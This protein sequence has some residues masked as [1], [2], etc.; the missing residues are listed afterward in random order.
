MNVVIPGTLITIIAS[1]HLRNFLR[2]HSRARFM[3]HPAAAKLS[4]AD[5]LLDRDLVDRTEP[6]HIQYY[7]PDFINDH[8]EATFEDLA[9]RKEDKV[10]LQLFMANSF[11][12]VLFGYQDCPFG[13]TVGIP[14]YYMW[15]TVEEVQFEEVIQMLWGKEIWKRQIALA[16]FVKNLS[17][18][19]LADLKDTLILS[20]KAKKYCI[21]EQ[22]LCA[23]EYNP[24]FDTFFSLGHFIVSYYFCALMNYQFNLLKKA[25]RILRVAMYS[26]VSVP[27]AYFCYNYYRDSNRKVHS[28]AVKKLASVG[29][30]YVEGG[31]EFWEKSERRGK[32][33][34]RI[35]DKGETFYE[36]DGSKI[37]M[38]LQYEKLRPRQALEVLKSIS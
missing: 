37:L 10:C 28:D 4:P 19:E 14:F 35:L 32:I 9:V 27:M 12:P 24:T 26:A 29:P 6:R 38:P 8:I 3:E 17:E 30:D 7:S 33:L 16:D 5:K 31:I 36:E 2:Q 11:D 13:Y 1:F 21:A 34:R 18:D 15:R 22:I 20:E 23:K 25:P